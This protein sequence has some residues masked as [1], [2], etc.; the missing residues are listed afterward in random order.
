[1]IP[2]RM[3]R[4]AYFVLLLLG[5]S[6]IVVPS[7]R[8]QT[9]TTVYSFSGLADGGGPAA[10]LLLDATGNLYGTT[11]YGGSAGGFGT[12]FRIDIAGNETVLHSFDDT[13]GQDPRSDLLLDSVG[14]LYGTTFVGG[15]FDAGTVFKLDSS[16]IL[17]TLHSFDPGDLGGITPTGGLLLDAHGNLYGTTWSG[18]GSCF[19]GTIYRLNLTG[20]LQYL[21]CFFGTDGYLPSAGVIRVGGS[22]YGVTQFGGAVNAGTVFRLDSD[23]TLTVVH[24]FSPGPD[25]SPV[26]S[27]I[28]D[29]QGNL[30]GTAQGT[31]TILRCKTHGG[32]GTVF[33]LDPLGNETILYTF[34]GGTD[35]AMPQGALL[36]DRAGNLYGTTYKGGNADLGTVFRISAN[37]QFK[38]LHSFAGGAEGARPTGRLIPDASG[39]LY[40]TTSAGGSANSGTIFKLTLKG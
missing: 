6:Q 23:G 27:L 1:M 15:A 18:G 14:S 9:V 4:R 19:D 24:S 35:G 32:C 29:G 3:R 11:R 28:T 37:G 39:N 5:A 38:T 34:K 21:H 13:D 26:A 7:A 31:Y 25:A 30:Y 2:A 16:G 22:L 12:I 10:G 40:G 17:S 8:S 33:E 36:R 20:N